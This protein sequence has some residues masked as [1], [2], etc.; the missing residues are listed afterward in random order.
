VV[1]DADANVFD[2]VFDATVG[3]WLMSR[4]AAGE[5]EGACGNDLAGLVPMRLDGR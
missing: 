1:T 4:Q 5:E 2:N 3:R